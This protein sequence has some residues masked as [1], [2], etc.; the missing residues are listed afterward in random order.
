MSTIYIYICLESQYSFLCVFCQINDEKLNGRN[1]KNNVIPD[2]L[3]VYY[4]F[5]CDSVNRLE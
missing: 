1:K 3:N 2:L 4:S 5:A